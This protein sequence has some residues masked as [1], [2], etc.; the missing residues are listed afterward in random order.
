[1]TFFSKLLGFICI[2]LFPAFS[3]PEAEAQDARRLVEKAFEYYRGKTSVSVVKMTIHRPD[4]ERSMTIKGWTKGLDKSLILITAPP[5]DEGNGTLKKGQEMWMYNPKVNRVIKIPPSMMSQA[6]L[7][8]DFSNN[9]LAKSD[10]LIHDYNHTLVGTE[11]VEGMKVYVVESK[12]KPQAPVV[13][14]MQKLRI[15][16][17]D[18]F[19]EEVFYDEYLEPVKMLSCHEIQMLGGKFFPKIMK[20]RKADEKEE[21]TVLE[22]KELA[23]D[24]NLP[25]SLFSL[26]SLRTRRR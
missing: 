2:G 6:W 10:T 7:G 21:Y 15:R 16:E 22:Y 13:W 4:W 1:M 24:M 18:I 14:G 9:D 25:D 5:K 12:P 19:L 11:T 20:M 8:S 26:S 17:D 3:V 23:F